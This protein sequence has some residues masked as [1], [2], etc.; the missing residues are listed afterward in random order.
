MS[1]IHIIVVCSQRVRREKK[2]GRMPLFFGF[3]K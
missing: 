3:S 1:C 2:E